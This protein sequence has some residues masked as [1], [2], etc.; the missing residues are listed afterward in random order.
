MTEEQGYAIIEL[1]ERVAVALEKLDH[2]RYI[3]TT[4]AEPTTFKAATVAAIKAR[5]LEEMGRA[6]LNGKVVFHAVD[7]LAALEDPTS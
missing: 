2:P 3:V 6:G 1:L 5:C 4:G 7:V